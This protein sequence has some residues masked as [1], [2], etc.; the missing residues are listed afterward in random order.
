MDPIALQQIKNTPLFKIVDVP[1]NILRPSEYNPRDID[2]EEYH[3]L[4]NSMKTDPDFIKVRPVIVNTLPEREGVIIGGQR[5]WEA[6][7]DLG[8]NTIPCIFV[9]VPL[10]KEKDW[11]LK[12]NNHSGKF[13][14]TRLR[15]MI[16]D[17]HEENYDLTGLGF[18]AEQVV[19]LLDPSTIVLDPKDDPNYNGTAGRKKKA[20][21]IKIAE[22]AELECP[23]CHTK[24]TYGTMTTVTPP[25]SE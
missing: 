11:N 6:A 20:P 13:N 19:M 8:W 7:L 12:D 4:V 16:L 22:G 25:V 23:E 17:L 3:S 15:E 21:G 10:N 2:S 9:S 14:D 24:F 1:L 18:N 5:R